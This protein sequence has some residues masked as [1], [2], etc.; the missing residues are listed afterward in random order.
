VGSSVSLLASAS[1][2]E[3]NNSK[4]IGAAE[5]EFAGG[6]TFADGVGGGNNRASNE[7]AI[8][9][10]ATAHGNAPHGPNPLHEFSSV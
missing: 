10:E 9:G 8:P 3:K 7:D 1:N 6:L 2:F 5:V 4:G